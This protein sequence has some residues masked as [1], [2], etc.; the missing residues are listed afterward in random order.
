MH[1]GPGYPTAEFGNPGEFYTDLSSG[2]VFQKQKLDG[3]L[4]LEWVLLPWTSQTIP[5][6]A[7]RAIDRVARAVWKW[8]TRAAVEV[9]FWLGL[10]GLLVLSAV[11]MAILAGYAGAA[12]LYRLEEFRRGIRWLW[13]GVILGAAIILATQSAHL[14]LQLFLP[15]EPDPKAGPI[16]AHS[17]R[18]LATTTPRRK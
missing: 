4:N 15:K 6:R 13:R 7:E 16:S 18:E 17:A 14:T 9:G 10:A 5:A 2:S 12:A 1:V 11:A 8:V 3:E